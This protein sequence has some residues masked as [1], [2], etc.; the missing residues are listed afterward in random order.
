MTRAQN[1]FPIKIDTLK[2]M[3]RF[4]RT[5][6]QATPQLKTQ[7]VVMLLL[8]SNKRGGKYHLSHC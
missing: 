4:I 6:M 1:C 8:V 7:E 2:E 3:G 5:L